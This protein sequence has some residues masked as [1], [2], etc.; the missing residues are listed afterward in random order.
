MG[1]ADYNKKVDF[2]DLFYL[3]LLTIFCESFLFLTFMIEKKIRSQIWKYSIVFDLFLFILLILNK[4]FKSNLLY[5]LASIFLPVLRPLFIM[6]IVLIIR[7]IGFDFS[8]F[9]PIVIFYF[10]I[11]FLLFLPSDKLE[12]L[13]N[14]IV[15][16][17]VA[18]IILFF[19]I[20]FSIFDN[21]R[22]IVRYKIP[23]S[24]REI[25]GAI[26]LG[27]GLIVFN[28]YFILLVVT[29][30]KRSSIKFTDEK[31]RKKGFVEG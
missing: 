25:S 1:L 19:I 13:N 12:T 9:I 28:Y 15:N 27:F 14:F 3:I 30:L 4:K 16:S 8:W 26:R 24:I 29:A 6:G 10:S 23:G 17:K 20:A 2:K 5:F 31:L 18:S 22:Y 11:W 21:N 7:T